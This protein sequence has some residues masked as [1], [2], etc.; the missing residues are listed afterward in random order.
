L[1]AGV[2]AA[3]EPDKLR[4][5]IKCQKKL[6]EWMNRLERLKWA[7]GSLRG[8]A[9]LFLVGPEPEGT[10]SVRISCASGWANTPAIGQYAPLLKAPPSKAPTRGT[11][12]GWEIAHEVVS[13]RPLFKTTGLKPR[14]EGYTCV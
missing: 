12:F 14:T 7:A 11:D 6:I 10:C 5:M 9:I 2:R 3:D 1:G 8:T 4:E 13:R